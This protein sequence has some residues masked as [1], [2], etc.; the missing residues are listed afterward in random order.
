MINTRV[1]APKTFCPWTPE[2]FMPRKCFVAKQFHAN[3]ET[4]LLRT[5]FFLSPSNELSIMSDVRIKA[6]ANAYEFFQHIIN[7]T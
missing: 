4:Y 6:P 3:L 1:S 5:T 2:G 7:H